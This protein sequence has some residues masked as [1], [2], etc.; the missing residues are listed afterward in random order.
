MRRR[1]NLRLCSHLVPKHLCL[2]TSTK[3]R[4]LC[5]DTWYPRNQHRLAP[6]Y[7]VS[8]LY[9]GT[10]TVPDF[11]PGHLKKGVF[12][13]GLS[14]N[15][16]RVP[17][18]TTQRLYGNRALKTPTI[19]FTAKV[20]SERVALMISKIEL[21]CTFYACLAMVWSISTVRHTLRWLVQ[22]LCESS[23]GKN[24]NMF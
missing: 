21:I 10:I 23:C 3:C 18:S 9:S 19:F 20:I 6:E 5:S 22:L 24:C 11:W 17:S 7:K 12:T 2:G 13:R 8:I 14:D 15:R 16:N 4:M 1:L